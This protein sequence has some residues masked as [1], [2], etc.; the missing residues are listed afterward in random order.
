[1]RRRYSAVEIAGA[2]A[3]TLPSETVTFHSREWCWT[4]GEGA[5]LR[6][7]RGDASR[8]GGAIVRCSARSTAPPAAPLSDR[9]RWGPPHWKPRTR[10][11]R[12]PN[13]R[14]RSDHFSGGVSSGDARL[15]SRGGKPIV[16]LRAAGSYRRGDRFAL[17][18]DRSRHRGAARAWLAEH[19]ARD[20]TCR[21]DGRRLGNRL[22]D[23]L[24]VSPLL[25]RLHRQCRC[26]CRDFRRPRV[27]HHV[28]DAREV[29]VAAGDG[30]GAH[31]SNRPTRR[32]ASRARRRA[33][34]RPPEAGETLQSP[35]RCSVRSGSDVD[36]PARSP[37]ERGRALPLRLRAVGWQG[38]TGRFAARRDP[39]ARAHRSRRP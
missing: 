25:R 12:A 3:I 21:W 18:C 33:R 26:R 37:V 38:T 29:R 2:R 9:R 23:L 7:A 15:R 36:R 27:T 20:A 11:M 34:A 10:S 14:I 4:G 22:A 30:Q 31:A 19:V 6:G 17:A 5:A 24:R 16:G 1:M 39:V 13:F 32:Q 35:D 28:W 8:C